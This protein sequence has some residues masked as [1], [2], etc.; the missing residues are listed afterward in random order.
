[1]KVQLLSDSDLLQER[2]ILYPRDFFKK[3]NHQRHLPSIMYWFKKC[4]WRFVKE[5]VK[6]VV[7]YRIIRIIWHFIYQWNRKTK[8]ENETYSLIFCC[9][10]MI[11]SSFTRCA[12]ASLFIAFL[13]VSLSSLI[14]KAILGWFS[15]S[16][17][18]I[19]IIFFFYNIKKKKL[20]FVFQSLFEIEN[21]KDAMTMIVYK[22]C[23]LWTRLMLRAQRWERNGVICTYTTIMQIVY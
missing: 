7:R 9:A 12:L 18:W 2:S 11:F 4:F 17:I 3:W 14:Q 21:I 8:W 5:S 13:S 23:S 6:S 15:F 20:Y 16:P 19:P 10:L 22:F 1:L